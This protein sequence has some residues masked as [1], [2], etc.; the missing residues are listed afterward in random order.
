MACFFTHRRIPIPKSPLKPY[1]K[2][3]EIQAPLVRVMDAE[4]Q[5]LGIMTT[6]DA[7]T[8]ADQQGLDLVEIQPA[9][10]PPVCKIIDDGKFRFEA[11][12]KATAARQKNPPPE[13]REIRL[14]PRTASADYDVKLGKIRQCL[15]SGDPVRVVLR[16]AG[17]EM[18]HP[19]GGV[20][21][22]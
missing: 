6:P 7:L 19:E 2:N 12:K 18:G 20:G 15:A 8:L 11:Q 5:P 14:R 21:P 16:F 10:T 17:R 9:S 3:H 22:V 4:G 13:I 1:R